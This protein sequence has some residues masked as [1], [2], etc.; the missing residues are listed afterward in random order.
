M[1]FVTTDSSEAVTIA[2][3]LTLSTVAAA[4]TDTD[5]FLVLDSSGNVDYRTG[6][7]VL[8]DIGA[9]T[10]SGSMTSFQL[11]DDDGTEVTISDAKEVKIIGSGV[12]TNWTDTD[13]GTD[14]DPYDLTITVDAAQ[15]GIT[16]ILATDVKIGED[17]QTKIDFE[18]ADEIHFYAANAHE[19]TL[20]ANELSPNTSDGIALGTSSKMWSDLFLASGAVINFNNG[21]ITATHSSNTLTIAGGTLAT[22]ALTASTGVF[23]GILKTDDATEATSTTDGSLQTD[24]GLSVVKDAVFGD[25]VKLLSDGA[26]LAFGADGDVTLTHDADD[27]LELNDSTFLGFASAAGTPATDNKVQGI[28][29]EFL[30][31]EAITQFDAVYVSTTTGRVGRADANDAAKLP[32]IGIAIEAQGSAGSSVRVLTHGVYRDDGGFGGNMTVGA[33]L[34]VSETPGTL[35]TTAPGDDGDFVQVMGVAV[36]VR[37]AFINPDMTIIEVA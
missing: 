19:V 16:S 20:A 18:T 13:N 29:I 17:D 27:G 4:G 15:T 7:Q 8:S 3:T 1:T 35:T 6:S 12:T 24:G 25:D 22:A 26:V 5:K 30:A 2:K 37:S 34:Y 32:A 31:V 28:V 9:G 36:G 11:E 33:D 21:D 23:S 10:G 14:G